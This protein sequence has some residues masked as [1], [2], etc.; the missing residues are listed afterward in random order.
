MSMKQKL[1]EQLKGRNIPILG[2]SFPLLSALHHS[3]SHLKSKHRRTL[4]VHSTVM[5]KLY[6][7]HPSVS[8][9]LPHVKANSFYFL[10]DHNFYAK[11]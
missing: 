6:G 11:Y 2:Q 5:I 9:L 8:S 1:Y 10:N 3:P 4:L 7:D